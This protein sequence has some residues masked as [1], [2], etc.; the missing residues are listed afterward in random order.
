V[1]DSQYIAADW[2]SP[3]SVALCRWLAAGRARLRRAC[4]G[5][6]TLVKARGER[7][8]IGHSL[9]QP[10]GSWAAV[11]ACAGWRSCS[12]LAACSQQQHHAHANMAEM[13]ACLSNNQL[14]L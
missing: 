13:V 7:Q 3:S 5:V 6:R 2:S 12:T 4:L 9:L 10:G 11:M 8:Y 14:S 1:I